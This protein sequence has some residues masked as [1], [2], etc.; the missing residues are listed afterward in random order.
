MC[1]LCQLCKGVFV[2]VLPV[3]ILCNYL[4]MLVGIVQVR[5]GE[6]INNRYTDKEQRFSRR[7]RGRVRQRDTERPSK[8]EKG[9]GSCE[10]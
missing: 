10:M 1:L 9:G 4:S 3:V 8:R 7:E 5:R 6:R 2:G